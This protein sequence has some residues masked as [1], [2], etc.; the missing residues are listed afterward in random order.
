MG[1]RSLHELRRAVLGHAHYMHCN[2]AAGGEAAHATENI[3]RTLPG[4]ALGLHAKRRARVCE[5]VERTILRVDAKTAPSY[6]PS[7]FS[8]ALAPSSTP[9]CLARTNP[10]PACHEA[11]CADRG[12]ST[13]AF[14]STKAQEARQSA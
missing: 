14:F 4:G 6:G 1:G 10:M 13:S 8:L 7:T 5:T 2:W 3:A 11:A 9:R 12:V